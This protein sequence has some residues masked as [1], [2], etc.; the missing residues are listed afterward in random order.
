VSTLNINFINAEVM[1]RHNKLT[2]LFS[3]VLLSFLVGGSGCAPAA[4]NNANRAYKQGDMVK[5]V[6]F[7]IQT[8]RQKHGYKKAVRLL[9]SV[10]EPTYENLYLDAQ[11]AGNR[12]DWD[13]AY[14]SYRAIERISSMISTLPEQPDPDGGTIKF[15]TVNVRDEVDH[16]IREAAEMHYR[17]GLDLERQGRHRE[18]A[19]AYTMA[20]SYVPNF[21]DS[22]ERYAI[23]REAA[24]RKIVFLPFENMTGQPIFGSLGEILADNAVV[25][26]LSDRRNLEFIDVISRDRLRSLLAENRIVMPAYFNEQSYADIGKQI[27][28]HSFVAGRILSIAVSYPPETYEVIHEEAEISKGRNQPKE[29]VR[30]TVTVVTRRALARMVTSYQVVDVERG[31]TVRTAN[32]PQ[33]VEIVIEFASFRGDERALSARS[34]RLVN[35]EPA[36]PPTE[37]DLVLHLSELIA[38]TL[39]R[40][41]VYF[42]N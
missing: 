17:N 13:A 40:E 33:E 36:Y 42:I 31:A 29:T 15:R 30:A 26:T 19:R 34:K 7:S 11:Y 5:A 6:E 2:I 18:A 41:V 1:M 9:K 25:T 35:T 28:I 4:W 8:L 37:N 23:N 3:V 38:Q 14:Q 10:L 20:M 32:L 16:S 12:E 22:S 21:R 27:G 24:I 39:S